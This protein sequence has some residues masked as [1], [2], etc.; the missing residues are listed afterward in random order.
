[1]KQITSQ[2]SAT[3]I[4]T[5]SHAIEVAVE[6]SQVYEQDFV[7]LE[8]PSIREFDVEPRKPS[9]ALG[10]NQVVFMTALP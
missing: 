10:V 3:G 4:A 5:K 8:Y 1:M 6:F 2:M 7:V 9:D